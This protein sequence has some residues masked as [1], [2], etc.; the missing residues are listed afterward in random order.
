MKMIFHFKAL[1]PENEKFERDYKISYESTL[2]DLHNCI[3]EDLGFDKNEMASFFMSDSN[4]SKLQE[5]TSEDM[6]YGEDDSDIEEL[7]P[8]CMGEI[9]LGHIIQHK[10][11]RLLYVFDLL[12]NR[13]LYLELIET[14]KDEDENGDKYPFTSKSIGEAPIQLI[15]DDVGDEVS[16]MFDDMYD[17]GYD[18]DEFSEF[19]DSYSE[20]EYY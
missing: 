13:G 4:W 10:H 19:N 16:E 5:F 1:S 18:D 8:M 11:E 15:E 12:S 3:V 14:L 20:E 6:F 2:L 9:I 17:D 7:T